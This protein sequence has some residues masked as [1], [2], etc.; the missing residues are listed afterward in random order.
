MSWG[1]SS[2]RK[3]TTSNH[4]TKTFT[5]SYGSDVLFQNNV[6]FAT[7]PLP[8]E[9]NDIVLADNEPEPPPLAF[10]SRITRLIGLNLIPRYLR[11]STSESHLRTNTSVHSQESA[12]PGTRDPDDNSRGFAQIDDI[13]SHPP[14]MRPG[15]DDQTVWPD[16]M[17]H[18]EV[19]GMQ[20]SDRRWW[21]NVRTK[22]TNKDSGL[23][24]DVFAIST[25]LSTQTDTVM[26]NKY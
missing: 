14:S 7:K 3:S 11:R 13:E 21:D 5:Q 22:Q 23:P 15:V 4:T 2:G 19:T 12:G 25:Q 20:Q 10:R 24:L 8:A 16:H 1:S 9:D 18:S 26:D 6:A 17:V